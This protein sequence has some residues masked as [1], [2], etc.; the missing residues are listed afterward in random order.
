MPP[1]ILC[2]VLLHVRGWERVHAL[3]PFFELKTQVVFQLFINFSLLHLFF[4]N[5]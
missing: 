1:C 5:L 2:H 4:E 3:A